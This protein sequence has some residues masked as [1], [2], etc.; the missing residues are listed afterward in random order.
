M[1]R[2]VL[3]GG[4]VSPTF[5]FGAGTYGSLTYGG[6]GMLYGGVPSTGSALLGAGAV[7]TSSSTMPGGVIR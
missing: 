2:V 5:I 1:A 6:S 7:V 3:G 4:T